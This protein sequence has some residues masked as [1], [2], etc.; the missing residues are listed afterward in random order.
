M[1]RSLFLFFRTLRAVLLLNFLLRIGIAIMAWCRNYL[2]ASLAREAPLALRAALHLGS[3][4]VLFVGF[5]D[6]VAVG[7]R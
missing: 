1:P 3:R 6:L 4:C 7:G 2:A 5:S